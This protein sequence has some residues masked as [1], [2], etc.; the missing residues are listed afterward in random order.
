[1]RKQGP[2]FVVRLQLPPDGASARS[3]R[4]VLKR[5]LRSY[6][7]KCLS[8]EELQLHAMPTPPDEASP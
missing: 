6:G 5:L 7:M 1:M 8:I 4:W 2:I 3:L